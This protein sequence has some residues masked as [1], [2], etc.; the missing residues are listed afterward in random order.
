MDAHSVFLVDAQ[1]AI[2]HSHV[3]AQGTVPES[4]T[5]LKG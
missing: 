2:R 5:C 3:Y 4:L 1:G